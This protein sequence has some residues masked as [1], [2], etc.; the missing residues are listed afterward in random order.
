ML[1]IDKG[2]RF[3]F[4]TNWSASS[5]TCFSDDSNVTMINGNK[6]PVKQLK[7]CQELLTIEGSTLIITQVLRTFEH[8]ESS[9]SKYSYIKISSMNFLLI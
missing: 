3:S 6:I 8:N 2:R 9:Q 5:S 7:P 1:T 4:G